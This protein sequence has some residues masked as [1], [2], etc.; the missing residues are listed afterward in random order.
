MRSAGEFGSA[1]GGGVPPWVEAV[2]PLRVD[3][4]KEKL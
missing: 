2:V 4:L 3:V 1:G